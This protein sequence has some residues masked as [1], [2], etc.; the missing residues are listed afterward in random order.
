MSEN[1]RGLFYTCQRFRRC[2]K[3][4]WYLRKFRVRDVKRVFTDRKKKYPNRQSIVRLGN[5]VN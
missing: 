5:L 1:G 3:T 4:P 2:N